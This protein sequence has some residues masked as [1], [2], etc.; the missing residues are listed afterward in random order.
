MTKMYNAAEDLDMEKRRVEAK[1]SSK[2]KPRQPVESDDDDPGSQ[3]KL[4]EPGKV[5]DD[6]RYE[7]VIIP[8]MQTS[9]PIPAERSAL[10]KFFRMGVPPIQKTPAAERIMLSPELAQYLLDHNYGGEVDVAASEFLGGNKGSIVRNRPLSKPHVESLSR[11]IKSGNFKFNGSPIVIAESG[12]LINGQHRTSATVSAGHSIDTLI[13]YG[14]PDSTIENIDHGKSR[15]YAD[16]L[17]IK[18]AQNHKRLA[19]VCSAIYSIEMD[20]WRGKGRIADY[21]LDEIYAKHRL[22]IDWALEHI[23]ARIEPNTQAAAREIVGTWAYMYPLATP[24]KMAQL[25]KQYVKGVNLK[26]D[27]PMKALR[28]LMGLGGKLTG[29][30]GRDKTARVMRCLEA[31]IRQQPLKQSRPDGNVIDRVRDWREGRQISSPMDEV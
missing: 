4:I 24:E 23:P 20:D 26:E 1:K 21:E 27:S 25:A 5:D 29:L 12:R 9:E 10:Y 3:S 6:E 17:Y 14:V 19:A 16:N 2:I 15:T 8:A 28:A 22:G 18:G 31:A 30:V 13:L 7:D 11:V